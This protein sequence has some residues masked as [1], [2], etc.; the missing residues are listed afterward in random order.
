MNPLDAP[1]IISIEK[2]RNFLDIGQNYDREGLDIAVI[3]AQNTHILPALGGPLYDKLL[4]DITD[5][6]TPTVDGSA[7]TGN[8]KILVESYIHPALRWAV[9][10]ELLLNSFLSVRD[11]GISRPNQGGNATLASK[12]DLNAK[13]ELA[14]VK[15]NKTLDRLNDYVDYSGSAT[16]PELSIQVNLA[17]EERDNKDYSTGPGFYAEYK[18]NYSNIDAIADYEQKN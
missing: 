11:N 2:L 17:S 9:Y 15:L 5:N 6:P 4:M 14:E 13:I 10:I 7:F 3:D 1:K 16:F 12:A 18:R 8:Y